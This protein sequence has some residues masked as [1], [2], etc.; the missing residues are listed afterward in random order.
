MRRAWDLLPSNDPL[1]KPFDTFAGCLIKFWVIVGLLAV[2]VVIISLPIYFIK[3]CDSYV[4]VKEY[5][6]EKKQWDDQKKVKEDYYKLNKIR[7]FSVINENLKQENVKEAL[8]VYREYHINE[9]EDIRAKEVKN[10]IESS[11]LAAINRTPNK[12]YRS[13]YDLYS[14]LYN[15]TYDNKYVAN[16]D[17]CKAKF[18]DQTRH[19]ACP[20]IISDVSINVANRKPG[21]GWGPDRRYANVSMK[22]KNISGKVIKKIS[23]NFKMPLFDG[24]RS[25]PHNYRKHILESN[26]TVKNGMTS[27][28]T[29]SYLYGGDGYKESYDWPR[30]G[31]IIEQVYIDFT[32]G[33]NISNNWE[34]FKICIE[35][36]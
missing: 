7:I 20:I 1:N 29:W 18:E 32:D 28:K 6:K 10:K 26:K 34:E 35:D 8:S 24:L 16:M 23:Y 31:Y 3:G 13:K 15:H 33:S 11:L 12:D 21:Q 22:W 2:I 27:S 36:K 5:E 30:M 17:S 25:S 9:D 14:E 19:K 4:T